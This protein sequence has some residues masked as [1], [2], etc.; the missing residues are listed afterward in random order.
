MGEIDSMLIDYTYQ[1][2][3]NQCIRRIFPNFNNL[4]VF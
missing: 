3:K 4:I 2:Y 1:L